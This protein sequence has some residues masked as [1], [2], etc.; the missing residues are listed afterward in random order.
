MP[1]SPNVAS[2]R[3]VD[4]I[5]ERLPCV[6]NKNLGFGVRMLQPAADRSLEDHRRWDLMQHEVADTLH[7]LSL[8][9][10]R[11]TALADRQACVFP[12]LFI[13]SIISHYNHCSLVENVPQ[14]R[15]I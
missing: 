11:C 15:S 2:L 7:R 12:N 14:I 6:R 1:K 10:L 5:P 8:Q 4:L 9:V 3:R 13:P